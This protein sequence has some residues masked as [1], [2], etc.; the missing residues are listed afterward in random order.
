MSWLQ[1]ILVNDQGRTKESA[2]TELQGLGNGAVVGVN[3]DADVSVLTIPE[4]SNMKAVRFTGQPSNFIR[5][6]HKLF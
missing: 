3:N 4:R 5:F 1:K 6:K 2:N